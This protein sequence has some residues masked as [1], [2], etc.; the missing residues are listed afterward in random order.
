MWGGVWAGP[1]ERR[2]VGSGSDRERHPCP[3]SPSPWSP[4]APLSAVVS[5]PPWPLGAPDLMVQSSSWKTQIVLGLN[6]TSPG[7]GQ[8]ACPSPLRS[9][10]INKMS[11]LSLWYGPAV[12]GAGLDIGTHFPWCPHKGAT[13]LS[14]SEPTRWHLMGIARGARGLTVT[15]VGQCVAPQQDLGRWTHGLSAIALPTDHAALSSSWRTCCKQRAW[16]R[17][18]GPGAALASPRCLLECFTSRLLGQRRPL[19]CWWDFEDPQDRP[20]SRNVRLR[21]QDHMGM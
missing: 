15:Q 10:C 6:S 4:R 19:C 5:L 1:W 8:G 9:C 11:S 13:S 20:V 17:P 18:A 7:K 12:I 14:Y 21:E 3:S 2:R 16:G